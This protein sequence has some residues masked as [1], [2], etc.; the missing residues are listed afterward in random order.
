[1]ISTKGSPPTVGPKETG[2]GE[3]VE[4]GEHELCVNSFPVLRQGLGEVAFLTV[5]RKAPVS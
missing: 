3:E 4:Y 1:M 2:G 5:K